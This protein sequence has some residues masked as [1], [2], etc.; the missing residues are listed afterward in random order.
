MGPVV[1]KLGFLKDKS[2][3]RQ[4]LSVFKIF[5]SVFCTSYGLSDEKTSKLGFFSA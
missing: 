5:G 4:I 1:K 2:S 3:K